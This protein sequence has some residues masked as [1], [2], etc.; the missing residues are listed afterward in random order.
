VTAVLLKFGGFDHVARSDRR[1]VLTGDRKRKGGR[2]NA[3]FMKL[4]SP[5]GSSWGARAS[6]PQHTK[7]EA[8]GFFRNV[9]N[10]I[11]T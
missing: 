10:H 1:E 8:L 11:K 7:M 6:L 4:T 2:R 5:C 9:G 3:R